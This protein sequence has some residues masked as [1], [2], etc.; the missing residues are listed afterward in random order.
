MWWAVASLTTVGCGDIDPITA[1][2]RFLGAA[3]AIMGIGMVAVPTGIL[4]AGF[5]EV[6]EKKNQERNDT[7]QHPQFCPHCGK[8]LRCPGF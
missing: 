8:K 5:V 1:V 6:L 3:I 2:G 4:S 7:E